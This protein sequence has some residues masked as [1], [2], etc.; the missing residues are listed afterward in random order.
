MSFLSSL[1]ANNTSK[2]REAKDE[3]KAECPYC[4]KSLSKIPGSKTK[5]PHCGE[6]MFVRTRPKDNVRV[7]ITKDE[8]EKI[9]EEW[10]EI[11]ITEEFK[12]RLSDSPLF[13]EKKYL[14]VKDSL[15]KKFG[16]PPKE[17]DVL[18]GLSNYL[19]QEYIKKDDWQEIKMI[20]FNQALFLHEQGKDCFYI[21]KEVAR[22]ELIILEKLDYFKRVEILTCN[23]QSCPECQKLSGKVFTIEQALKEMPIPVK[24]CTCKLNPK[25]LGGWCRCMYVSVID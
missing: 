21:L 4:H 10:H 25:A 14:A 16:F 9:K 19:L 13:S 2:Y 5:C 7:V 23:D 6:F 17:D 18:W 1:F 11:A 8:A 20:Y 24:E 22:C 15:S 3:R 12:K